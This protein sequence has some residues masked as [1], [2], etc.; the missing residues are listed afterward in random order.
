M[1]AGSG[2]K[3]NG[4]MDVEL[5]WI[6]FLGDRRAFGV[7]VETVKEVKIWICTFGSCGVNVF[8]I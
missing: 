2:S 3:S 4:I 5:R 7:I 1:S 8:D 6:L